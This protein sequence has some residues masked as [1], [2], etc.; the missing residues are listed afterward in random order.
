MHRSVTGIVKRVRRPFRRRTAPGTAP[1]TVIIDP[2]SPPPEISV[3]S[4][5]PERFDESESVDVD[6]LPDFVG[7]EEVTWVNVVGFGDAN[8]IRRIGDIFHIHQLV[9]EDVVNVHQRA[10][11]EEYDGQLFIVARMVSLTDGTGDDHDLRIESEQISLIVGKNYVV[12]FQE[13]PGDCFDP[14]RSRLRKAAGRVRQA[15]ADYLAY[16]LLDAIV[17]GY[18]P[19]LERFGEEL[20][21][22]EDQFEGHHGHSTVHR[23]HQL[24]SDLLTL[25]RSA[26]PHREAINS[27]LRTDMPLITAETRVYLRDCYDHTVQ[28][29]DVAES[30]RELCSD[31]R[32]LHFS[33]MSLRQNDIMK[34]LTVM[35]TIF[36]PLSFIASLYGMNFD[37]HVSKWNMP[38]LQYKYGYPCVLALMLIVAGGLLVFFRRRGWIGERWEE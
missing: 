31:L 19:V 3:I 15:G 33:Q 32:D 1:G 28:I 12:T 21:A 22:V 35:A 16:S 7:R 13:K 4:Y 26:W 8:V 17:D 36:I 30:S 27:L 25:R 23:I 9:L 24:R 10:K 6:R 11:V 5:G 38:E 20:D 34:V 29:I 18:F 14:I 2:G 37:H